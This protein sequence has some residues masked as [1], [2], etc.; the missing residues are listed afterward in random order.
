MEICENRTRYCDIG[1][2]TGLPWDEF[3]S[4]KDLTRATH[5]DPE[6]ETFTYGDVPDDNPRAANLRKLKAGDIILFYARLVDWRDGSFIEQSGFYFIGYIEVRQVH[7]EIIERPRQPVFKTVNKN[8][9]IIR[10]ECSHH[11][12]DGFWVFKGTRRSSRF[13]HAVSFT[14]KTV[15]YCGI[16]DR[17]G[18]QIDWN[19]YQSEIA[20]LGSYFRSARIIDNEKQVERLWRWIHNR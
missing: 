7:S 18:K 9:H 6:F 2:V 16:R 20:A 1:S 15:E 13:E 17:A 3:M 14:R 19:R 5:N 10:A 11:G 12:Y 4:D 8:A